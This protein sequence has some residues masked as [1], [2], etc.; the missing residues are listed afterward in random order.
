MR[1][2]SDKGPK[3]RLRARITEFSY[4]PVH[5]GLVIGKSA[6]LGLESFRRAISLLMTSSFEHVD[7]EDDVIGDLLIRTAVLRRISREKL[8]N[9]VIQN[10]KPLMS[11]EEILHLDL[12]AEIELEE[13]SL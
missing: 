7:L 1:Q 11:G 10:V 9:F 13:E 8:V 5:D 3:C 6:P 2:I 4:P 12:H